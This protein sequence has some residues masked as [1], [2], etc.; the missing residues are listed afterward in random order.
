MKLTN[1]LKGLALS[2]VLVLVSTCALAQQ[3]DATFER[4]FDVDEPIEL[5]V[6]AG[7]GSI[8][9]RQG[10]AGTARVFGELT[11]HNGRGFGGFWR[12]GSRLTD[13]EIA[14]LV[15]RF[16]SE[17]PVGLSGRVLTVGHI[18]EE[19][20]RGFSVSYRIEVPAAT[21]VRSR[22]GSGHTRIE[23]IQGRIE[24]R[25]GSGGV[26][27][28]EVGG[29]I[30]ASSGSGSVSVDVVTAGDVNVSTGSGSIHLA[31][32]DGALAARAGSGSIAVDGQPDG[33]WNLSTGSGSIRL[34]LPAEAAFDLDART[35][36]GGVSTE[37][38]LTIQVTADRHRLQGQV[39]G[40]G[41]MITART[42][43][44]GIRIE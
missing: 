18:E 26:T 43:S 40:G 10:G 44:G 3:P 2:S 23:G 6:A 8:E 25:T 19:W 27:L 37:H 4:A 12:R 7:S 17:P 34:R 15:R 30:E 33:D 5:D 24:A 38:P 31:G 36:S 21:E 1:H 29:D 16:E 20:Q 41:P 13:E 28:K 39:R 22:A 14:E 9:I 42:G 32:V 11:V 35:G